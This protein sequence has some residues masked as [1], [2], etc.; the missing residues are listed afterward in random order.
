LKIIDAVW[1]KRNI[2]VDTVEFEFDSGDGSAVVDEI[3]H[4]ERQYNVA[5]VPAGNAQIMTALQ[6]NGYSFIE[7][8]LHFFISRG[9]LRLNSVQKRLSEA[10]VLEEMD[11]DDIECLFSEMRKNMFD[12]DR[13]YV[14]PAFSR[15]QAA[16]RYIGWTKDELSRGTILYKMVYK[17]ASIGFIGANPGKVMSF[18]GGM[19]TDYKKSGLGINVITKNYEST[20]KL[21]AKHVEG[22]VSSNNPGV[23]KM[24]IDTGW[25]MNAVVN[26]F[27]KHKDMASAR[28]KCNV[29]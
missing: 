15:E 13:V 16:N 22:A 21:G 10:V 28:P 24:Y 20:L 8:M 6:K 19:Y 26:I 4:S 29:A 2:G 11:A 5:K 27:I 3:L 18:L 14:D 25:Q 12:T 17:G 7:S 9:D 1:E 23:W